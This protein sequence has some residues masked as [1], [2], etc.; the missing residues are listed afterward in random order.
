MVVN[1]DSAA[2]QDAHLFLDHLPGHQAVGP[3]G[4]QSE[5]LPVFDAHA[6]HFVQKDRQ[7]DIRP[8]HPGL[9]VDDDGHGPSGG[10][11]FRKGKAS[12][13]AFKGL[14]NGRMGVRKGLGLLAKEGFS[15]VGYGPG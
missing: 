4:Y 11:N 7:E 15:L 1:L 9:I 8:G 12:D 14:P 3:V 2:C 6:V 10:N 5:D 13:G